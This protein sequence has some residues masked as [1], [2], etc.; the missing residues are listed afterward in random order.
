MLLE[1][2]VTRRTSITIVTY[3]FL[4]SL[5]RL[6]HWPLK[7]FNF[8]LCLRISSRAASNTSQRENITLIIL[9]C[10]FNEAYL[11]LRR[12][13]F[14]AKVTQRVWHAICYACREFKQVHPRVRDVILIKLFDSMHL[15]RPCLVRMEKV[16]IGLQ[17]YSYC[18]I[19]L[20][21][22]NI[23]AGRTARYFVSL[24]RRYRSASIFQLFA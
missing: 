2:D 6:I 16:A 10:D 23:M 3:I 24:A 8:Y 1:T 21:L 7:V 13:S 19:D 5:F 15:S 11:S 12:I 17:K 14:I 20:P 4:S 9:T 22:R 18:H